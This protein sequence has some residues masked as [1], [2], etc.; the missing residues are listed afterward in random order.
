[1]FVTV[2]DLVGADMLP[3]M[4]ILPRSRKSLW[5]IFTII[6]ARKRLFS[7]RVSK[8]NIEPLRTHLSTIVRCIHHQDILLFKINTHVGING[9]GKDL[10]GGADT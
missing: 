8:I 4:S 3:R 6:Y 10:S 5:T 9:R 7:S 2:E 1:M